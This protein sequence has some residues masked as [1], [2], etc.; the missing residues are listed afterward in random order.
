[1]LGRLDARSARRQRNPPFR[2]RAGAAERLA[3]LGHPPSLARD[4]AGR[5]SARPARQ[6][7]ASASTP[8]AATTRSSASRA[9]C[10]RTRI[11]IATSAP[12]ASWKPSSRGFRPTRSTPSPASSSC[13]STRCISSTPRAARR[14]GS[15]T[16][17]S[18]FG[19]IPDLVNYWLTGELTAEFTNATT[20]QFIDARTRTWAT[21]MLQALDMPTRLCRSWSSRARSSARSA[22]DALGVA[23]RHAG[24]RARVPRHRVGRRRRPAERPRAFLSSGTWSLLGTEL[25][26]PVITPQS[27]RAQLHERG[28]RLRHD[29]PAEEH[30]RAVAAAGVPAR[31][32]P[33]RGMTSAT[34][35]LLALAAERARRSGRSSI[36][37]IRRSCIRAT[38]WRRSP[39]TAARPASR[40]PEA[41]ARLRARDPREPGVQ[42]PRRARIARGA[43]RARAS[44]RSASSA[45]ARATGC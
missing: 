43:D 36:P 5:W 7:K 44:R 45:A 38:W 25:A 14:R 27:A 8:G 32:G 34:T 20:T 1:M 15:S 18:R 13:R 19:T 24:G 4:Q 10:S 28:R 42:V 41:P 2:Q 31:T 30:R 3:A 12:T 40:R 21:D 37:I 39:T 11:T 6:S 9:S 16:R 23:A 33:R 35:S 22:R 29:A 17:R 26:A